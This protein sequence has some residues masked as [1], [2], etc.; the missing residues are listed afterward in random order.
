MKIKIT[1]FNLRN[2]PSWKVNL[3]PLST[4]VITRMEGRGRAK[5]RK[6]ITNPNQ[7]IG[8]LIPLRE[9]RTNSDELFLWM[10]GGQSRAER[11][12]SLIC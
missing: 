2:N 10:G 5:K 6:K 1:Q 7:I 8:D 11:M 4:P 12:V 3:L 9:S